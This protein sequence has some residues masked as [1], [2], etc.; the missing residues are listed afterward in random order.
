M[1]G[2]V[3]VFYEI[4]QPLVSFRLIGIVDLEHLQVAL[5]FIINDKNRY[6]GLIRILRGKHVLCLTR[7][8][9]EEKD[10]GKDATHVGFDVDGLWRLDSNERVSD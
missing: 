10:E 4:P 7:T 8:N 2:L 1:I 6:I 9:T 5:I 3:G